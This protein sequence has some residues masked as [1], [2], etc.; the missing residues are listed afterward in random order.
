MIPAT[1]ME[2][3][4]DNVIFQKLGDK[5]SAFFVTNKREF[6]FIKFQNGAVDNFEIKNKAYH[7]N[8]QVTLT[9]AQKLIFRNNYVINWPLN[10][11]EL[12]R[13]KIFY[14]KY[15]R[16]H[17]IQSPLLLQIVN[18]E[19]DT[20]KRIRL[21]TALNEL[22]RKTFLTKCFTILGFGVT[23]VGLAGGLGALFTYSINGDTTLF[24][25]FGA[26]LAVGLTGDCLAYIINLK[27]KKVI[28][29]LVKTLNE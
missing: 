4:D 22:K 9:T 26:I 21:L 17:I 1:I 12:H 8:N 15:D 27:K 24:L 6:N 14:E 2:I 18:L 10:K 25:P 5:E 13:N 7:K 16:K 19:P 3:N 29:N 20:N 11:F 23:C 28:N